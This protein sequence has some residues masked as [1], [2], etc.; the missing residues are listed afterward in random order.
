[1]HT[2]PAIQIEVKRAY[3]AIARYRTSEARVRLEAL[4]LGE[5]FV[6]NTMEGLIRKRGNVLSRRYQGV[7]RV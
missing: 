6:N 1:M 5:S 3:Y 4:G 7:H 2:V